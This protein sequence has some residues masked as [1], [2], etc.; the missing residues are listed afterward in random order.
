[1]CCSKLPVPRRCDF[2]YLIELAFSH[3]DSSHQITG[4]DIENIT[5]SV[6][7][8]GLT[9][10]KR[11]VD[12][13]ETEPKRRD[14]IGKMRI[15]EELGLEALAGEEC[16]YLGSKSVLTFAGNTNLV[17]FLKLC[18][19]HGRTQMRDSR[20]ILATSSIDM[21]SSRSGVADVI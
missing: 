18:D 1:M 11:G 2:V 5:R 8:L 6:D 15:D 13:S 10:A 20:M 16:D 19:L 3:V 21:M 4:E 17:H 14:I 12:I 7:N 9:E